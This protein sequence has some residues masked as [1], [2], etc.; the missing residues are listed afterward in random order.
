MLDAICLFRVFP[1]VETAKV[2]DEVAGYPS[3]SLKADAF[4]GAG[5]SR[6]NAHTFSLALKNCFCLSDY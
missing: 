5:F 1:V 3:Y 6:F 4:S 2:A